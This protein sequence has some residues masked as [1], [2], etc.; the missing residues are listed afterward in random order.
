M[1]GKIK[2]AVIVIGTV[3]VTLASG[4]LIGKNF[5]KNQTPTE[6]IGNKNSITE[7]TTETPTLM[8]TENELTT[9]NTNFSD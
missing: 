9:V 3:L 2:R 6:K 7:L 8:T 1:T 4:F 5:Q